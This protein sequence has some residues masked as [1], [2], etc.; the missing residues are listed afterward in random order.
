MGKD[1]VLERLSQT[2]DSAHFVVTATT[3]SPRS[4]ESDGV[5]YHFV[6]SERFSRMVENSELLEW[7]EVYGNRYGVPRCQVEEALESGRDVVVRVD[8]QGAMTIKRAMPQAVSIFLVAPSMEELE[9][10]LRTRGTESAGD[11]ERR[12]NTARDEMKA[13]DSF[14]YVVVNDTV[15]D[16]ADRIMA[17][18]KAE[19]GRA[20]N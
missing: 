16:A 18:V 19:K 9:R 17:I 12:I 14:D 15:N 6:T 3:R 5:D 11:I 13:Q 8:I 4:Q 20:D 7:A 2:M 1:S 10:R